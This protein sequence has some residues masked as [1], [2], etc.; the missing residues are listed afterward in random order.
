MSGV[1]TASGFIVDRTAAS[2]FVSGTYGHSH[3]FEPRSGLPAGFFPSSRA[4][5]R[6]RIHD[7][8]EA[9]SYG[10]PLSTL[11]GCITSS[12]RVPCHFYRE[13]RVPLREEMP[14]LLVYAR[15]RASAADR[16]LPASS[17]EIFLSRCP[18]FTVYGKSDLCSLIDVR[19]DLKL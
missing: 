15:T 16:S 11:L 18:L 6:N 13:R 12:S 5:R 4:E 19:I 1:P 14:R 17:S 3:P 10:P 7:D 8:S 9:R 2:L